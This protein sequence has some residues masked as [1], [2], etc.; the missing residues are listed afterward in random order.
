MFACISGPVCM[1]VLSGYRS[2]SSLEFGLGVV[3][4]QGSFLVS[5]DR[6]LECKCERKGGSQSLPVRI[7]GCVALSLDLVK[8]ADDRGAYP[9]PSV[10]SPTAALPFATVCTVVR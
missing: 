6:S 10:P 1:G 7:D 9:F 5:G 8:D 2:R 3:R 4:G